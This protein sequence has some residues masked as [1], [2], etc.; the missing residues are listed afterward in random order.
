MFFFLTSYSKVV[1]LIIQKEIFKFI[2]NNF[3]AY[4]SFRKFCMDVKHLPPGNNFF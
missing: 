3:Q 1:N 2:S 4:I